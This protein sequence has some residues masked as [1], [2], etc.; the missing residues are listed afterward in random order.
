MTDELRAPD[1]RPHDQALE[2]PFDPE[3][4]R[5]V[6]PVDPELPDRLGDGIGEAS[7]ADALDQRLDV[8]IDDDAD[9]R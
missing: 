5:E 6:D 4:E 3:D 9:G 8:P 1:P 7:E 2:V